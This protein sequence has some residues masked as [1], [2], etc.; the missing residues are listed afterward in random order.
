METIM[1]FFHVIAGAGLALAVVFSA[2]AQAQQPKVFNL[3]YVGRQ[4]SPEGQGITAFAEEI[5]K[6]SNGRFEI[7]QHPGG[8]LGGEREMLEGLQIG[9]VDLVVPATAVVGNFVPEVQIL[10]IPFLFRNFDHAQAVLD[11]PIGQEMLAKFPAKGLVGLALGWE[12]L[13]S[14]H[15]Q[16]AAGGEP[17][18]PERA[19]A[20]HNGESNAPHGLARP[21][22][23]PDPHGSPGGLH[24]AADAYC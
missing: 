23:A 1:R 2:P 5:K 4:A 11:G 6:R 19:Q 7:R 3:G 10:D 8:A 24:G 13:S 14:A 12:W 18:R 22:C 16:Q 20:P 17:R 15:E 9:T 21:R